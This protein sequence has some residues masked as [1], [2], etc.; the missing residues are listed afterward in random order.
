MSTFIESPLFTTKSGI[1]TVH[2]IALN[3]KLGP[4]L[5]IQRSHM[6]A[7][8][9]INVKLTDLEFKLRGTVHGVDS[10]ESYGDFLRRIGMNMTSEKE[11]NIECSVRPKPLLPQVNIIMTDVRQTLFICTAFHDDNSTTCFFVN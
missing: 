4:A 6:N 1:T 5:R 2:D 9:N 3:D 8:G 10:T 7:S 11:V